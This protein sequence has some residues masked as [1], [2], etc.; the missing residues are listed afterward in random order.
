MLHLYID[1]GSTAS[2]GTAC[3]EGG[4][5]EVCTWL[6][7]VGVTGDVTLDSFSTGGDVIFKV[8]P[9]LFSASGG[10]ITGDL[11][12]TKVGDLVFDSGAGG[13]SVTLDMGQ[14]VGAALSLDTIPAGT[15]VN[16]P[17]PTP[18]L[19]LVAGAAFLAT[20]GRRRDTKR[21]SN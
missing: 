10:R 21:R 8:D 4:G 19:G 14:A 6:I 2:V 13:G 5:D 18:L 9:A 15:V 7:D 17:E 12:P 16:V 1:G 3:E 11:G 20:L